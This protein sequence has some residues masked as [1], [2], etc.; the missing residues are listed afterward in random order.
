MRKPENQA[1]GSQP[2]SPVCKPWKVPR[3][4]AGDAQL[5]LWGTLHSKITR[6]IAEAETL[7]QR[8]ERK[9]GQEAVAAFEHA[10]VSRRLSLA[11]YWD[12]FMQDNS[13]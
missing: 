2:S 8:A 10:A 13:I 7:Q 11:P 6:Y 3:S 9:R 4:K 1:P 5:V 12:S